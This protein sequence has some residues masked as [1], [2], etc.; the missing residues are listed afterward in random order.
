MKRIFKIACLVMILLSLLGVPKTQI[1]AAGSKRQ[2]NVFTWAMYIPDQVVKKFEKETGI[3]V[4]YSLFSSNEEMLAKLQA[5]K[6]SQYD[7]IVCSDYIIEVM[8]KQKNKLIQP[9]DQSQISNFKN[10][11]PNYLN[12]D[13][14]PGNKY[15]LPYVAG[16]PM[17]IYNSDKVKIP[18]KGYKDLWNPALKDSVVIIDD[19]RTVIGIALKKLGY[20][21]NETDPKRLNLAK[22]E[23]KK[24]RPNIKIFDAD[25]PH[26]GLISGDVTVGFMFGSQASAAVKVN[27]H[28][29]IVYPEE[30]MLVGIDNFVIPAKA[31]HKKE[32][33]TLINFI[34]DGQNNN[35]ATSIIEYVSTNKAARKYMSSSYLNNPAVYLPA[36]KLKGAEHLVDIGAAAKT[37]DL[38]WSEFKQ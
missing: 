21:V 10:I 26:N 18:L 33:E 7:L 28:F 2:V 12:Q 30:G 38:I 9:I 37:Y 4:N 6:G 1:N 20:S 35:L 31:P 29:K 11:D 27:P 34:L 16:S 19:S 13:F 8:R 17:I 24:L 36:Q 22:E 23:L 14:D 32:A 15:S 5:V 3:K 25:T